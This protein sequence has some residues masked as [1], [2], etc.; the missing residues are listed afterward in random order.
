[1]DPLIKSQLAGGAKA[2]KN[3]AVAWFRVTFPDNY[4]RADSKTYKGSHMLR[5]TDDGLEWCRAAVAELDA[6]DMPKSAWTWLIADALEDYERALLPALTVPPQYL[7]PHDRGPVTSS[8]ATPV[9]IRVP[10][11]FIVDD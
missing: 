2:L 6:Q 11:K 10:D 1:M 4:N 9:Y 8:T 7:P 3:N 5:I